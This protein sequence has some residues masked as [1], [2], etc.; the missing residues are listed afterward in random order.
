MVY[1]RGKGK[2]YYYRFRFGGRIIHEST[3]TRSKTV[4]REAER[5]RRRE[6]VEKWNKI[7][8]RT[9]PPKLAKAADNWLEKRKGFLAPSTLETYRAALK[10]LREVLGYTIV[11]DITAE[12]ITHYQ[13]T[14]TKEGAAPATINKEV[15]CLGSILKHYDQW[16]EIQKDVKMLKEHE[17]IG[18]ALEPSEE[19]RLLQAASSVGNHQGHWSPI[20]TVTVL[21][22]NTG[23][24]HSEVRQLRWK[25]MDIANSL[26][27]VETSKTEAGRGRPVPLN[28]P[29]RAALEVWAGRFPNRKPEDFVFPACE[30]G[31]IDPGRPIANWRTA[32]R[33]ACR[34]A[35]L[36]GLRF[37]DLRHSAVTK[38]LEK[39][40]PIAVVAQI[41]GWS[42]STAFR[43]V[44]RYGHIRP[45]A[46][47]RA[48]EAIATPEIEEGVH[49]IDNQAGNLVKSSRPN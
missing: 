7:E 38:L 8:K 18:K 34:A 12:D 37:H 48:L 21:D 24:R 4:A 25:D 30:N 14:R 36:P 2:I 15:T 26:L 28:P 32:W 40:F 5:I 9:L 35:G 41:L 42:A 1:T 10:R 13:K 3:K 46:Q 45:E 44:K 29:A 6:L 22:L 27:T 47:R 19:V 16:S 43:M 33:N 49:Q 17:N 11:C 39:G 31:K 23:L 20:Y